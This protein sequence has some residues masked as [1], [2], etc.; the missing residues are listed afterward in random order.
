MPLNQPPQIDDDLCLF[1]TTITNPN[2]A[3]SALITYSCNST[4]DPDLTPQNIVDLA[5]NALAGSLDDQLDSTS[6]FLKTDVT[7]GNG[8]RQ[9]GVAESSVGP[10]IGEN[11]V[12]SPSAQVA[13]LVK[14]TTNLAGKRNR[15]RI[16]IPW[17]LDKSHILPD[18]VISDVTVAAIQVSVSAWA[19]NLANVGLPLCIANRHLVVTPPQVKPHV[20]TITLGPGVTGIHVENVVATQRRRVGR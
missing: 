18:G 9:S 19:V 13:V 5:H 11:V 4:T 6:E 16:Y 15:G 10:V 2:G 8:T 1:R 7:V 12:S 20:D 14:L 17:F 3:R